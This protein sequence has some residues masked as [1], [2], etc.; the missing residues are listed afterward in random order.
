MPDSPQPVAR[1]DVVTDERFGVPLADPYRWMENEDAELDTWL[2]GQS[3]YTRAFFDE[4]PDRAALLARIT[5]LTEGSGR[6]LAYQLVGDSVFQLWQP[7]DADVPVLRVRTGDTSRVLLDP[8][9]IPGAEHSYLDW[10]AP[11]PDGRLVACGVSQGGSERSA[12]HI[13]DVASG[14]LI[15]ETVPGRIDR[16]VTWLPDSDGFLYLTYPERELDTP[17]AHR[18]DNSRTVLHRLGTPASADVVILTSGHNPTAPFDP[19]SR[20]FVLAPAGSSWLVAVIVHSAIGDHV[21]EDMSECTIHV[22]PRDALLADPARCPWGTIAGRDDQVVAFAVRGED[23]YVVTTLRAP[24]GELLAVSMAEPDLASAR[25]V[26]PGGERVL[27]GVRTVGDHL[28]LHEREAGQTRFR[29]VSPD[30]ESREIPVP[31]DG[32]LLNWATHPSRAE[33]YLTLNSLTDAP[34]VYRY[35]GDSL[36][37]TDWLPASPAD[38]SDIVCTDLRVP[39]R[40]GALVPLRVL[41][42]TGIVLDGTNPTL[43]NG[44]GSYGLVG[45]RLFAPDMLAWYERGG[46][47]AV[48]GLRGGGEFGRE[49]H[50]AG[51]LLNKEN[52]ITDMIDCA[53][54]L[55]REGYTNPARLAGR[56]ASAGGIPTGGGLV[57]RPDLWAAMV[58]GVP[59]TN[60]T[61]MEFTENGPINV[62]EFGSV[63]TETGLRSLLLTDSY[64]RVED[65][66]PYPAVLITGGRNDGRVVVWQPAKMAARLQAAT[67]SG[68]PVLLRV[69]MHAG[70]GMGST[71]TQR[72]ELSADL[73]AFLWH[74]FKMT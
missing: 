48:A 41:H 10:F 70:H 17:P 73:L 62:P 31:M 29:R 43:L 9:T 64:L 53:E 58:M 72:D 16:P 7:P 38:F 42:K 8:A 21:D 1:V 36:T 69:E 46:V 28:L 71:R 13:V 44:Y 32:A 45:S 55:I 11:S 26:V 12:L 24:R 30:G 4:L 5:E 61:R 14:T 40:D 51:R 56:G 57:R 33:A 68:H 2:T 27:V 37:A 23:M 52:T 39:A 35:D 6:D 50:E 25:V 74:E 19:V 34:Q 59:V 54:F 3:D 47:Q 49:W 22:A 20:P 63:A 65:G 66:T 67:T 15:D 60:S 18:Y